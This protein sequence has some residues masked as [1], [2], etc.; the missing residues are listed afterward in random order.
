M[1]KRKKPAWGLIIITSVLL[2][3]LGYIFIK[4]QNMIYAQ[5][6]YMEDIQARID[7]EINLNN[8]LLKQKEE[9]NSREYIEKVAREKL[10][11]VKHGERVFVDIN[12]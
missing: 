12:R 7:E 11:M 6:S 5:Q 3:Y 10:D 2:I 4:Q 8:K 1:N 9:I